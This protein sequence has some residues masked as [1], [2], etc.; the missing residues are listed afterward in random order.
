MGMPASGLCLLRSG[1]QIEYSTAHCHNSE[2]YKCRSSD[3]CAAV[4][5][6]QQAVQALACVLS[7][8][9]HAVMLLCHTLVQRR[10][11]SNL[12]EGMASSL[13]LKL[14]DRSFTPDAVGRTI[15]SDSWAASPLPATA[16]SGFRSQAP[17][18]AQSASGTAQTWQDDDAP[19]TNRLQPDSTTG[20][21]HAGA[22]SMLVS[23]KCC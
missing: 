6:A 8:H 19:G 12:S 22:I 18:E 15:P 1:R 13:Q 7:G 9:L 10:P 16:A 3:A 14:T 2:F 11:D 20:A 21:C 23:G 5:L 17:D 4:L